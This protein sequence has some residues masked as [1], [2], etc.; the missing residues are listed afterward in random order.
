MTFISGYGNIKP[1]TFT[2]YPYK[3]TIETISA[4]LLL[5]PLVEEEHSTHGLIIK[6]YQKSF[7]GKKQKGFIKL[8]YL[9][10]GHI[11]SSKK[12]DDEGNPFPPYTD[13]LL[14]MEYSAA[15]TYIYWTEQSRNFSI[16]SPQK[17]ILS[18]GLLIENIKFYKEIS[19]KLD[20]EIMVEAS[21]SAWGSSTTAKLEYNKKN[22]DLLDR[23]ESTLQVFKKYQSLS[24]FKSA[25]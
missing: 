21:S 1:I 11:D 2:Y 20:L 5:Y 17:Q 16:A 10:G 23:V 7:F 12:I 19:N 4:L 14:G 18:Y 9:P 15:H 13:I 22:R 6:L 24:D 25:T 8:E 3:T